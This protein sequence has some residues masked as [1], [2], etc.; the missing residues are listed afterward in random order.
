MQ[1]LNE[2]LGKL[3]ATSIEVL[4]MP[5][6]RVNHQTLFMGMVKRIK[7]EKW[8][9]QSTVR[10]LDE[11][12]LEI[13]REPN[14]V[15]LHKLLLAPLK[16][17]VGYQARRG[18]WGKPYQVHAFETALAAIDADPTSAQL[19]QNTLQNNGG[20][21][22][23][24]KQNKK[25]GQKNPNNGQNP[26]NR[27]GQG[28]QDRGRS[29]SRDRDGNRNRDR[30]QSRNGRFT[31]V[32][33]WPAH[34]AYL[35]VQGNG[36]VKEIQEHFSGHCFKCGHS[37]HR[38]AKCRIYTS[39]TPVLSLCS[40]CWQGFH[41]SCKSYKF[42]K[43]HGDGTEGRVHK[44]ENMLEQMRDQVQPYPPPFPYPFPYP[45]PQQSLTKIVTEIEEE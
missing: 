15:E 4:R 25:Q 12:M 40:T 5:I 20:K 14:P 24:K 10:K 44:L 32:A 2:S 21:P 19:P 30:S 27:Q 39:R 26:Q 22:K 41:D 43:P 33:P 6:E 16:E 17:V 3:K 34:K 35:N 29:K 31:T 28:G 13:E 8:L 7:R 18:S 38:A 42:R 36:L 1:K 37:S 23:P 9:P 11:A 45:Y